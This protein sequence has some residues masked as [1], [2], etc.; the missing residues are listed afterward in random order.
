M[1]PV[2]YVRH[3]ARLK[4][5]FLRSFLAYGPEANS[6][7]TMQ[8]PFASAGSVLGLLL[9]TATGGKGLV[10]FARKSD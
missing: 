10:G 3:P 5:L 1:L 2:D 4:S 6:K 8:S 7:L 9:V